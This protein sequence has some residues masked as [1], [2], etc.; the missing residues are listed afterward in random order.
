MSPLWIES[1]PSLGQ[2]WPEP[3]RP[4]FPAPEHCDLWTTPERLGQ[5]TDSINSECPT[6][7]E[8]IYIYMDGC[9]L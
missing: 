9:V 7:D 4:R 2:I 6:Y 1:S 3:S 8:Y 5:R